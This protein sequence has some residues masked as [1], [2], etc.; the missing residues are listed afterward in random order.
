MTHIEDGKTNVTPEN[1]RIYSMENKEIIRNENDQH[2]TDSRLKYYSFWTQRN[3]FPSL[4]I[5]TWKFLEL[6]KVELKMTEFYPANYTFFNTKHGVNELFEVTDEYAFAGT[7]PGELKLKTG[8]VVE[9]I[10][11]YPSNGLLAFG[12][13]A[14]SFGV[15][16]TKFVT[17]RVVSPV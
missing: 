2:V 1:K 4:L 8:D 13:S 15:F 10:L 11:K 14:G 3:M 17:Q 5:E 9:L 16:S 12:K 6:W 7:I